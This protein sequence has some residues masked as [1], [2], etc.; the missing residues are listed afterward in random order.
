VTLLVLDLR[1][2]R[3]RGRV[4]CTLFELAQDFG[5]DVGSGRI[6]DPPEGRPE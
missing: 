1:P 6:V 3:L 5:H 4:A 2:S